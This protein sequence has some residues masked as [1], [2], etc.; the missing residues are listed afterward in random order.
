M[1]SPWRA[2][3]RWSWDRW[4]FHR[5][6]IGVVFLALGVPAVVLVLAGMGSGSEWAAGARQMFFLASFLAALVVSKGLVGDAWTGG[7]IVWWIQKGESAVRFVV[8][9][10]VLD[11]LF[12]F[13]LAVLWAA[14]GAVTLAV[15]SGSPDGVFLCALPV[16]ALGT[17]LGVS[18]VALLSAAGSERD[19]D[20]AVLLLLLGAV[21]HAGL[22]E[23]VPAWLGALAQAVLP[24]LGSLGELQGALDRGDVG[25]ALQASLWPVLY[26]GA[27]WAGTLGL[28]IRRMPR[29]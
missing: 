28:T 16:Q 27:L 23:N 9:R 10:L 17:A 5:P 26:T 25:T 12:A 1:R 20:L 14:T 22:L 15:R 8:I 4:L 21:W 29:P 19:S 6:G 24:P 3:W 11:T 2:G 13:A 18:L 7:Y